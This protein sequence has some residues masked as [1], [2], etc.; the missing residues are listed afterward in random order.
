MREIMESVFSV[1]YLVVIILLGIWFMRNHRG[2]KQYKLF[3]IATLILGFGD[4]FHLV[5][6]IAANITGSTE[7]F[8]AALNIGTLITSA[9]MTVFYVILYQIWRMRYEVAGKRGLTASVYVLAF[10][11]ILLCLLPQNEWLSANPSYLW[12]I[13]RNIPFLLLGIVIIAIYYSK[14][15]QHNDRSFRFFWLA[16]LL[17][18]AFYIPV[19][20]FADTL[21]IIGILMLPKTC[22]YVWAVRMGRKAVTAARKK[23]E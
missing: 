12:G 17:S 9:T 4:A 5:P 18:F 20:L 7:D 1:A 6:R 15:K 10:A 19:V 13:Y 21:P 8:T 14:A 23:D 22:M 11:R 16:V 2:N 3:G